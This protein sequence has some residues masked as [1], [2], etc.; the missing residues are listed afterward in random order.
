MAPVQAA[1]TPRQITTQSP[2]H[3]A[4][5]PAPLLVGVGSHEA[6]TAGS[7]K[8]LLHFK[9]LKAISSWW[10]SPKAGKMRAEEK[11]SMSAVQ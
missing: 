7:M 1:A 6:I 10:T 5:R 2:Y 3:P 9:C 8:N 4:D 11:K